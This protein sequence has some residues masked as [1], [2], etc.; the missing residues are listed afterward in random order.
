MLEANADYVSESKPGL[1]Y[2]KHEDKLARLRERR[3]KTRRL[4]AKRRIIVD[5]LSTVQLN[6]PVPAK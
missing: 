3:G 5:P 2:I 4:F 6:C 1:C